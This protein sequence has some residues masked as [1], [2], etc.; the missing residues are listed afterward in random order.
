MNDI[1]CPTYKNIIFHI[2]FYFTWSRNNIKIGT[3]LKPFLPNYIQA[4]G[5]VDEFIKVS[6]PD[7]Q[8]NNLG[9]KVGYSNCFLYQQSIYS[10]NNQILNIF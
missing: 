6:R 10:F 9:L 1:D 8:F 3:N 4:L 2:Q 5:S 7:G